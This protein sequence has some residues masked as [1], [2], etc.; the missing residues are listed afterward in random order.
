MIFFLSDGMLLIEVD[1]VLK[2]GGYFVLTSPATELHG[3]SL[4]TKR[5]SLLKPIEELTEKLCWSLLAQ[6]D[7]TFIW[8][9]TVDAYCYTSG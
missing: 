9:K 8:Q 5:N 6:Q 3:N 1:R 7:D 4:S 2:P